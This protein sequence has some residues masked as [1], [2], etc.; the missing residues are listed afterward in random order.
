V[1]L[2]CIEGCR[3]FIMGKFKVQLCHLTT[4]RWLNWIKLLCMIFTSRWWINLN[5]YLYVSKLLYFAN[6]EIFRC[7]NLA[8]ILYGQEDNFSKRFWCPFEACVVRGFISVIYV[9]NPALSFLFLLSKGP[10]VLDEV[11]VAI[12]FT[13]K[14]WF[15]YIFLSFGP[16]KFKTFFMLLKIFGSVIPGF[17][18]PSK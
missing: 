1:G 2:L 7:H 5:I 3:L 13:T 4:E 11:W 15:S 12:R 6:E 17:W 10:H 18:L 8:F 16:Y 9:P 14:D